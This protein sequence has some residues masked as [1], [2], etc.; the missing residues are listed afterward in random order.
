MWHQTAS[1][2]MGFQERAELDTA[3]FSFVNC[4][5]DLKYLLIFPI[6]L[7]IWIKIHMNDNIFPV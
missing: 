1:Q 7:Q 2:T 4:E 3:V 6:N 5:F